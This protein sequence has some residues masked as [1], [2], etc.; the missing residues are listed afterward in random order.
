M[1]RRTASASY[2]FT[3]AFFSSI[4]E[5]L[6]GQYV[7]F[8]VLHEKVEPFPCLKIYRRK[9]FYE[10]IVSIYWDG[11][12]EFYSSWTEGERK[13]RCALLLLLWKWPNF[14]RV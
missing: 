14:S 8:H 1:D 10:P 12:A 5:K 2:Y 11:M 7:F 4:I 6:L 3:D 13:K 9:A